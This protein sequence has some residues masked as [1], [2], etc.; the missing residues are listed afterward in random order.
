MPDVIL[1]IRVH[2]PKSFKL[3]FLLAEKNTNPPRSKSISKSKRDDYLIL[4]EE[5]PRFERNK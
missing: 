4:G 1:K 2:R 3:I 5:S